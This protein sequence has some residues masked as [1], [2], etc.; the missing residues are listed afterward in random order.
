MGVAEEE[1]VRA[2]LQASE[3]RTQDA[4]AM[5]DLLAEDVV[6]QVNVPTSPVI[7]GRH[8]ARDEIVRQNAVSTGMLPGSELKMI[9]SAADTVFTERVDVVEIYGRR[10]TFHI[11][12][13]FEVRDGRI[14]V[15]RE[16]FDTLDAA[17]QLG[18]DPNRF[19][20]GLGERAA[21]P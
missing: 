19:Y 11:A 15:W 14:A 20:E 16:Y 12:G 9:G 6:W 8:A 3:G 17:R 2:F 10:A 5:C 13:I 4:D 1:L 7:T 21:G 18:A